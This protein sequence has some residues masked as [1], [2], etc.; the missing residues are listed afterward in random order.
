MYTFGKRSG[1]NLKTYQASKH[2]PYIST[3]KSQKNSQK[4]KITGFNKREY[5]S[6][7]SR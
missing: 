7:L 6:K 1:A 5:E 4:V 2:I 3:N